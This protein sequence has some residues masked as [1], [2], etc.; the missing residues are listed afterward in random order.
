MS[1][2]LNRA[3]STN[4]I[5]STQPSSQPP[6][7]PQLPSSNKHYR[8]TIAYNSLPFPHRNSSISPRNNAGSTPP[9]KPLPTTLGQEKKTE[10]SK[11]QTVSSAKVHQAAATTNIIT[12]PP[13][14][15][16]RSASQTLST[17][18][19]HKKTTTSDGFSNTNPFGT[20]TIP[21]KNGT[22]PSLPLINSS[23]TTEGKE[24]ETETPKQPD[25]SE[26]LNRA[27]TSNSLIFPKKPL[28]PPPQSKSPRKSTTSDG[29]TTVQNPLRDIP[30]SPKRKETGPI[31]PLITSSEIETPKQMIP[32]KKPRFS[33]RK[34]RTR[35]EDILRRQLP[36]STVDKSSNRDK[37]KW[38]KSLSSETANEAQKDLS[39]SDKTLRIRQK[40]KGSNPDTPVASGVSSN[41]LKEMIQVSKLDPRAIFR[42][43]DPS[44]MKVLRYCDSISQNWKKAL[45]HN[46]DVLESMTE[47]ASQLLESD[48]KSKAR[49][50][51][52]FVES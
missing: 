52:E 5:N 42:D 50:K 28:P 31:L 37:R 3:D 12:V 26:Q 19:V 10:T 2:P 8:R 49:I 16:S 18:K 47:Y 7:N 33:L 6:L 11:L 13:E 17:R 41:V 1:N 43:N 32:D 22:G 45:L 44:T 34:A 51:A 15:T 25:D 40:R 24:K 46:E 9:I 39:R 48:E 36:V 14:E 38:R 4:E 21:P 20:P 29:T 30:T 27:A 23:A 35:C